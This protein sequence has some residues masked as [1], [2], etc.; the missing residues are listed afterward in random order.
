MFA[1][2]QQY[3]WL[4]YAGPLPSAAVVSSPSNCAGGW[5]TS[6]FFSRD[7]EVK[8]VDSPGP[9]RRLDSYA[10]IVPQRGAD[11]TAAAPSPSADATGHRTVPG[12][13]RTAESDG[14]GDRPRMVLPDQGL[15]FA[16]DQA[17]KVTISLF[18]LR[19]HAPSK[20]ASASAP[21]SAY[22]RSVSHRLCL[23]NQLCRSWRE[24]PRPRR[25]VT[26]CSSSRSASSLS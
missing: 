3:C 21:A 16:Q 5:F 2:P 18:G 7:L 12:G 13:G 1:T 11:N 23:L 24:G 9:Y 4:P 26:R 14:E 17:Q 19:V 22:G 15:M 6:G 25:K 10:D 8:Q 20:T